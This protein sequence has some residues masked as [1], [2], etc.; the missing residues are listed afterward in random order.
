VRA[1]HADFYIVTAAMIIALV[2]SDV[3]LRSIV[4]RLSE[5]KSLRAK[6]IE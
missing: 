5:Y 2:P 3:S 6:H 1:K 4:D